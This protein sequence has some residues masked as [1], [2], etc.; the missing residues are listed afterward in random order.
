MIRRYLSRL[1][2]VPNALYRNRGMLV[3]GSIT[4]PCALGRSGAGWKRREGDGVTPIGSHP[5]RRLHFRSDRGARPR[6]GLEMRAIRAGEWWCDD[7][8]DRAYN[9]LV[10]GRKMPETSEEC[11]MRADQLYNLVVEVGFNDAPVVRGRGS[12]IFLHVARTGL[13]PTAGCV[14]LLEPDLRRLLPFIGP[15]TKLVIN[16]PTVSRKV[17]SRP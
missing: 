4:F 16:S 13:T 7:V 11:L 1:I 10:S 5:L 9:R 6:C 3:A 12:G 14:A 2:V 15:L 8:A 17:R